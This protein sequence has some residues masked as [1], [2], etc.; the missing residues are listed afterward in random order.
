MVLIG[1][2]RSIVSVHGICSICHYKLYQT[3]K[4]IILIKKYIYYSLTLT[5]FDLTGCR[6]HK[7]YPAL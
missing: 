7:L 6:T 2:T 5:Q 3:L 4:Y 1:T